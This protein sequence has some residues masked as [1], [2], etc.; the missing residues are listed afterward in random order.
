LAA[1]RRSLTWNHMESRTSSRVAFSSKV[2]KPYLSTQ[3]LLSQPSF[4]S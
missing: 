1:A 4:S 3:R 2:L